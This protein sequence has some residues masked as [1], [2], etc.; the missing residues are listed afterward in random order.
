MARVDFPEQVKVALAKR[1]SYVCSNPDCRV[2]TVAPADVD[3][4]KVIYVGEAAHICAAAEGGPRYDKN[5]SDEQRKGIENAIFVCSTCADMIDKN[6]GADFSVKALRIWKEQHETWVRSNLNR[7][8]DSPISVVA[9]RH[10]AHGKGE[11][12][13]LDVQSAVIIE[14]GT[15]VKA[16][17]EGTVTGTRIGPPRRG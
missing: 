6:N 8:P 4:T 3:A 10:E 14:A 5:M 7:R 1:A 2:L 15:V 16:S 9:G 12:T 17:G 11:V 13:G